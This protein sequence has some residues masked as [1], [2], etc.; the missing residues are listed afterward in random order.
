MYL[1]YK[2]VRIPED[3]LTFLCP[4]P[5]YLTLMEEGYFRSKTYY[6]SHPDQLPEKYPLFTR[7]YKYNPS[8]PT[9]KLLAPAK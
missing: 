4:D 6:E 8:S 7:R 2:H 5:E 1:F 9:N 3:Q